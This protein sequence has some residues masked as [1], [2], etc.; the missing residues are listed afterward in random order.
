MQNLWFWVEE[1]FSMELNSDESH[2][3]KILKENLQNGLKK[4]N[5]KE[6][7]E[8]NYLDENIKNEENWISGKM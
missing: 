1:E 2:N 6:V 4:L 5:I 8:D 7:D 3:L